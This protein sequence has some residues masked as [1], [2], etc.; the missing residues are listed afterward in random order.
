MLNCEVYIIDS[1]RAHD[2]MM[3]VHLCDWLM[4]ASYLRML[5]SW[6]VCALMRRVTTVGRNV[7]TTLTF[8]SYLVQKRN[9]P[10]STVLHWSEETWHSSELAWG[11]SSN[12]LISPVK[13]KKK[14]KP[15]SL[16]RYIWLR[17]IFFAETEPNEKLDRLT[18]FICP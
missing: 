3:C 6:S 7:H 1:F 17:F 8:I 2:L 13:N 11:V 14:K 10:L 18:V 5:N 16:L 4:D 15:A 12:S 9:C